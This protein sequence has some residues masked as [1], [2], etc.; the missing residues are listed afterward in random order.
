MWNVI[1]SEKG[2]WSHYYGFFEED[3]GG[4]SFKIDNQTN[5]SM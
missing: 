3:Y 5:F 2:V 4:N 1:T